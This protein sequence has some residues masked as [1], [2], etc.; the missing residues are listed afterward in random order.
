MRGFTPDHN[1]IILAVFRD[2][3]LMTDPSIQIITMVSLNVGLLLILRPFDT[4]VAYKYKCLYNLNT[5]YLS[6]CVS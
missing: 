1:C 3:W 6:G 4:N 2:H 5:L